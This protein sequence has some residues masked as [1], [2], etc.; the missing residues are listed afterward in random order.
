MFLNSDLRTQITLRPATSEDFAM[1][2]N[3]Y[4]ETMKPLT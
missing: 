2:L 4:L 1:A 3:L